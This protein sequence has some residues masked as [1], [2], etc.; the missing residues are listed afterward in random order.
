MSLVRVLV[1]E[2]DVSLG[3]VVQRG[4][5][6]D[7]HAVDLERT[8]AGGP[9]GG[10]LNPYHLVVLDLGLPDGDGLALC[11]ELRGDRRI[12]PGSCC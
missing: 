9:A 11:R 3:T 7:G 1:V 12:R 10:R 6:E 2:D 4:L 8:L 5:V